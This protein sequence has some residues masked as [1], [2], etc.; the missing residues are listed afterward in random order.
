MTAAAAARCLLPLVH[1]DVAVPR[2]AL[3]QARGRFSCAPW[4]AVHHANTLPLD[5]SCSS[6]PSPG[7][8]G[9]DAQA[10]LTQTLT[11]HKGLE[12]NRVVG[13]RAKGLL[14]S[15]VRHWLD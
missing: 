13:R 5:N 2:V 6:L 7:H 15:G 8:T 10:V 1:E 4:T 9:D 11:R 12:A 14:H 3:S